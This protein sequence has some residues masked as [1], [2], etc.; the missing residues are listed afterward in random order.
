[1]LNQKIYF[2]LFANTGISTPCKKFI[3]TPLSKIKF[4]KYRKKEQ[5][6]DCFCYFPVFLSLFTIKLS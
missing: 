1:M 2:M 4:F 6:L 5:D 3:I